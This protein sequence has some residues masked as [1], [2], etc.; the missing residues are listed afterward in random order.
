MLTL[1]AML[2]RF[3]SKTE[4]IS[5]MLFFQK[6]ISLLFILPWIVK[7]GRPSLKSN[8]YGLIFIRSIAGLL[9]FGS[10]F[11]AVQYTSL[12]NAILL[13]NAS[14]FLIPFLG[15]IFLKCPINH[16]LW[17][18]IFLG[19]IGIA[20]ILKPFSGSINPGML[21]ALFAALM[22]AIM[23]ITLRRLSQTEK[24][25][26]TNFYY[27][28][29]GAIVCAPLAIWHWQTPSSDVFWM[30]LGMGFFS[31][32]GQIGFTKAFEWAKPQQLGPFSYVAVIYSGIIDWI[33]VGKYPG[34]LSIAGII[35]VCLGGILTIRFSKSLPMQ[36]V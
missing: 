2:S 30:L 27:F 32:L 13:D 10:L 36:K 17:P 4:T 20:L 18:G 12:V 1:V 16:K 5:T 23:M 9:S 8:H 7:Y 22:D 3:V 31:S 25:Y 26:T 6:T 34:L 24:Y 33:L 21:F 11:A 35:L 15:W 29:I 19:F 28:L 14:P